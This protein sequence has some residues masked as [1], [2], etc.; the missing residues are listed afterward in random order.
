MTL[1][2]RGFWKLRYRLYDRDIYRPLR[3]GRGTR[4]NPLTFDDLAPLLKALDRT[5]EP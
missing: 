5:G 3:E 1:L 4:E 2:Q